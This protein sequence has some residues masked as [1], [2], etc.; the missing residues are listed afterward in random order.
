MKPV[1]MAFENGFVA[2]SHQIYIFLAALMSRICI[3]TAIKIGFA[4]C[5]FLSTW[6]RGNLSYVK[7]V[8]M[9]LFKC[10][11][12][13]KRVKLPSFVYEENT[14]AR[15]SESHRIKLVTLN[16][17]NLLWNNIWC[18]TRSMSD[19]PYLYVAWLCSCAM[20]KANGNFF[21]LYISA[22][23]GDE[24]AEAISV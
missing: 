19:A 22:D 3:G 4:A 18:A 16:A 2:P 15:D 12:F 9:S 1:E 5:I 24:A 11:R 23:G 6:R 7:F 13:M 10:Y 21:C 17:G 20:R 8:A 14:T